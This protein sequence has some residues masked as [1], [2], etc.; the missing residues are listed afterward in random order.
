MSV[1]N[2]AY[3]LIVI[4]LFQSGEVFNEFYQPYSYEACMQERYALIDSLRDDATVDH[5]HVK[6]E[7][8]R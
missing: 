4:I 3:A 8:I 1:L 7:A 6:C 2:A 5:Y